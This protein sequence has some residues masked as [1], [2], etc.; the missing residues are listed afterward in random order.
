MKWINVKLQLSDDDKRDALREYR[1]LVR[2]LEG[3]FRVEKPHIYYEHLK[4]YLSDIINKQDLPGFGDEKTVFNLQH[5]D[6]EILNLPWSIAELN[7]KQIQATENLF[8]TNSFQTVRED[9]FKPLPKPL[10][11]LVVFS[12]PKDVSRLAY[13]EERDKLLL[14]FEKSIEYNDIEIDFTEDATLDTIKNY[15]NSRQYHIL[16]YSGHSA[17]DEKNKQAVLALE[18]NFLNYIA[19]TAKEFTDLIQN[20]KYKPP[21]IVLSSCQSAQAKVKGEDQSENYAQALNGLTNHLIEAGIPAVIGMGMSVL[22]EYAAV[23]TTDFYKQL[24]K[25]HDLHTAFKKALETTKTAEYEATGEL[26]LQWII[27]KLYVSQKI[28]EIVDWQ[29]ETEETPQRQISRFKN[30]I[31]ERDEDFVFRGRRAEQKQALEALRN[32]KSVII[33]GQG[34]LGKTTLAEQLIYRLAI[35]GNI[36]TFVFRHTDNLPQDIIE[37]IENFLKQ[38]KPGQLKAVEELLSKEKNAPKDIFARKIELYLEILDKCDKKIYFLFDNLETFLDLQTHDF[39]KENRRLEEIIDIISQKFPVII[40][41]RYPV[42][43]KNWVEVNLNTVGFSD[44]MQ[45]IKQTN[46]FALVGF[47]LYQGNSDKTK[48][49]KLT[50]DRIIKL[51]FEKTG[52]NYRVIEMLNNLILKEFD[53]S[54]LEKSLENEEDFLQ[55]ILHIGDIKAK[56]NENLLFDDLYELLS[57]TQKTILQALAGFNVPVTPQAIQMQ[58]DL[59]ENL[60]EDELHY[61]RQASLCEKTAT[62]RNSFILNNIIKQ[63]LADKPQIIGFSHQ[64]AGEYFETEGNL[65]QAFEH[66]YQAGNK[67]KTEEIGVKLSNTLYNYQYFSNSLYFALKTYDLIKEDADWNILNKIGMNFD[68][69]G[70]LDDSLKFYEKAKNKAKQAGDLDGEGTTLNNISQ[71]YKARGDY[72]TALKYLEESLQ[73]QRE[74]GDKSGEGTTLNNMATTAYARGDYE[75]AL[76]YL[77]ESLQIRREI[78]DM[79]G[80]AISSFNIGMTYLLNLNKPEKGFEYLMEA[81]KINQKV[82]NYELQQALINVFR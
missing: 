49:Y 14:A 23:F 37:R 17:F 41:S 45:K 62:S 24:Y 76:K 26:P 59:D 16:H 72:E 11:I 60:I 7:G 63:L 13:E 35:A 75:T 53:F 6:N 4:E 19:V 70:K 34:G 52:G 9:I 33:T 8:L 10:R 71:I 55:K 46:I 58:T 74:I 3:I 79:N 1:S 82:E 47:I 21:L 42:P 30:L 64:K 5:T 48:K 28:N 15:L 25:K 31:Y 57:Q 38:H 78:G 2:Y 18:D 61:L 20:A 56:I 68:R 39:T 73:I 69:L 54:V 32:N 65:A 80:V 29:A 67:E 43:N 36:E 77:E 12:A 40:T 22:D 66:Y 44:F 81:Y 50:Y 51:I 27:P